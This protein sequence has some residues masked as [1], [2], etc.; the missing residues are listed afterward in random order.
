LVCCLICGEEVSVHEIKSSEFI[1]C[2]DCSKKIYIERREGALTTA[3]CKCGTI[4][5]E[6][7][8]GVWHNHPNKK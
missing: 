4:I 7:G 2:P 3:R 8:G 6:E 1:K 5:Y